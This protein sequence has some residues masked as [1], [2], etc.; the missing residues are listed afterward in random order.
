MYGSNYDD[1]IRQVLGYSNY[2]VNDKKE[3]NKKKENDEER[4]QIS[5]YYPDIYNVVYPMINKRCKEVN[6]DI[7]E[8]L[9]EDLV[10]EIYYEL[11]GDDEDDEDIKINVNIK[12]N[13]DSKKTKD[14][15]TLRQEIREK[16]LHRNRNNKEEIKIINENRGKHCKK[17]NKNIR[18][19]IKILIIR[20]LLNTRKHCF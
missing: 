16:E 8:S 2:K 4:I 6:S 17:K 15:N 11:E 7:N 19:L 10:D 1:Y 3:E 5:K 18:D 13:K 9:L 14:I 20:E 12:E